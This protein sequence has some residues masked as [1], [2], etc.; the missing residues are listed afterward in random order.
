MKKILLLTAV[1][2]FL[3]GCADNLNI[4][5]S[6]PLDQDRKDEIIEVPVAELAKKGINDASKAVVIDVATGKQVASQ[7]TW[8]GL[9]IFPAEVKA[10]GTAEYRIKEGKAEE[11][12]TR[13]YGAFFPQRKDDLTWENDLI[14][15][16]AYGPALEAT[17]ELS[18]GYDVWV[19][20]TNDMVVD[21]RYDLEFCEES[22]KMKEELLASG[23]K[24][25]YRTFRDS[26]SFHIDHGNG[27]DYYAVGRTLGCGAMAPYTEGQL[28]MVNNFITY[29]ILDN[30][31]LRYT[32]HLTYAPSEADGK[33]VVEDRLISLDAGTHFNRA[34]VKY[35]NAET[36]EYEPITAAAGIILHGTEDYVLNPEAG[37][38]Y[39]ADPV[40]EKFGQTYLG[41][42]F[43]EGEW[44]AKVDCNHILAVSEQTSSDGLE[45]YF[46]AGWNKFGFPTPE[47]WGGYVENQAALLKSP[48]VVSYK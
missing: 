35:T 7:L 33:T 42:I 9:L 44:E 28:W 10:C 12:T 1:C 30:G 43:P 32:C 29:E 16:R 37:C 21:L 13:A 23:D 17:G 47:D 2:G 15:F 11:Y 25:A 22:M 20:R 14:S 41:V 5:V 3:A 34:T 19:K 36:G 40:H 39:Y 46:G 4:T 26:I 38:I 31:P 8:D 18:C 24:K 45:Y 6:N 48:L 27:C